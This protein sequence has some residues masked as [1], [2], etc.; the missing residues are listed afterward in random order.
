MHKIHLISSNHVLFESGFCMH[1]LFES[2]FCIRVLFESGF[3]MHVL[4]GSGL[5]HESMVSI[6]SSNF[7]FRRFSRFCLRH[8][9]IVYRLIDAPLK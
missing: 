1:V 3:R 6:Y 9:P 4:F 8:A 5:K 7:I 2:G